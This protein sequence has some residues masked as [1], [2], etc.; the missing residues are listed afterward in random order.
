MW[1]KKNTDHRS[2]HRSDLSKEQK[3]AMND[4]AFPRP[5]MQFPPRSGGRRMR[6]KTNRRRGKTNRRRGKTNRRRRKH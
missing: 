2:D 5:P 6:Y 1:H 3:Q 4:A